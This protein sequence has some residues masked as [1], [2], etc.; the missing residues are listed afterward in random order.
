MT[1]TITRVPVM[2]T[3][4]HPVSIYGS[5]DKRRPRMLH[6]A[7]RYHWTLTWLLAC[8]TANLLWS[9]VIR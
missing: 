4:S 7:R 9:L 8:G 2:A 3:T 5:A 6:L 1:S